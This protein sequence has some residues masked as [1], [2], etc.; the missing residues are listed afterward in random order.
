M[1]NEEHVNHARVEVE[2]DDSQGFWFAKAREVVVV[3]AD[4]PTTAKGSGRVPTTSFGRWV[5]AVSRDLTI[6]SGLAVAFA[7]FEEV[8]LSESDHM[9]AVGYDIEQV[10]EE[11]ERKERIRTRIAQGTSEYH[12]ELI[13]ELVVEGEA[14]DVTLLST[15]LAEEHGLEAPE[16]TKVLRRMKVEAL[17]PWSEEE[18]LDAHANGMEAYV[19][20][21]TEAR[22][23][24]V[25][26]AKECARRARLTAD[27]AC[28]RTLGLSIYGM[29]QAFI[30]AGMASLVLD[31][32]SD[33][34]HEN[35]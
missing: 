27:S 29:R 15:Y 9:F 4:P 1:P 30:K 32:P 34:E 6:A 2:A 7:R 13:E 19:E 28:A 22:L 26:D 16:I 33:L 5:F 3:P 8:Y 24:G 21:M 23:A 10:I 14:M 18:L 25:T 20:G 11:F 35:H 12:A 31:V 17:I